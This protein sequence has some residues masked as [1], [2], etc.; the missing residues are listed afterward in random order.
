[1]K[2]EFDLRELYV[3]ADDLQNVAPKQMR[4]AVTAVTVAETKAVQAR[5]KAAAPRDRP[6]L[7]TRGIRRKLYK[8]ADNISGT[9]YTVPDPRGRPVGL[10][11]EFGTSKMEPQPFLS[12]AIEP[13]QDA[14]PMACLY[15][16]NPLHPGAGGG[17]DEQP[18]DGDDA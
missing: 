4:K 17:G 18:A 13:S 16:I 11:V 7:S 3:L 5:A 6:W 9:V 14:W 1:M 10:F 2:V 8:N 12:V 15:A